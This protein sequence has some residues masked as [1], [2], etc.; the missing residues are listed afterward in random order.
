[1]QIWVALGVSIKGMALLYTQS[2]RKDLQKKETP[3]FHAVFLVS[4]FFISK[5]EFSSID[6]AWW[7]RLQSVWDKIVD[8]QLFFFALFFF[9]FI[10]YMSHFSGAKR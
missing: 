4:Q 10:S 1:M 8:M 6:S 9:S 5:K 7:K 2:L 3:L